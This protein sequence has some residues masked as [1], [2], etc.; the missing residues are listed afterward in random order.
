MPPGPAQRAKSRTT[1]RSAGFASADH[2]ARRARGYGAGRHTSIAG[3]SI[4]VLVSSSDTLVVIDW[5]TSA[6]LADPGILA[7]GS[8]TVTRSRHAAR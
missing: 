2:L 1:Q 4:D 3:A 8:S 6:A 5:E 7:T